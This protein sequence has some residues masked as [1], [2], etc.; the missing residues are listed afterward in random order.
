MLIPCSEKL[1]VEL[2]IED[3]H[4][5][6]AMHREG[7][8]VRQPGAGHDDRRSP[9][10]NWYIRCRDLSDP[11]EGKTA[12]LE[13]QRLQE[14]GLHIISFAYVY[15]RPEVTSSNPEPLPRWTSVYA[16]TPWI[17]DI[18]PCSEEAYLHQIL[19]R[20]ERY[21]EEKRAQ[22]QAGKPEAFLDDGIGIS[23]YSEL[24]GI[25]FR[26]DIDPFVLPWRQDIVDEE[27]Y[28]DTL[29]HMFN[30]LEQYRLSPNARM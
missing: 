12:K 4:E 28:R 15:H 23:N 10:G 6:V 19:P 29:D 16:P 5:V 22:L 18:Q 20:L 30:Y 14:L 17:D 1:N 25:G 24:G 9:D 27:V 3:P 7:T 21:Y 8:S 11:Q 26:H 13:L 2:A